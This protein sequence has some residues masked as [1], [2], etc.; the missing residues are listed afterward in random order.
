VITD[1]AIWLRETVEVRIDR[2]IIF[3][4]RR[5]REAWN[6]IFHASG[7]AARDELLLES[8]VSN[9]FDREEWRW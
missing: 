3:P 6:E 7:Q 1:R 2:W 8:A 9:E 5:L 4:A